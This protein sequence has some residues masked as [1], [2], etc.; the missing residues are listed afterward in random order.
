MMK[1]RPIG[2]P[3]FSPSF[4]LAEGADEGAACEESSELD[5]ESSVKTGPV[6]DSV[7]LPSSSTTRLSVR[8]AVGSPLSHAVD[9]L[10]KT[11]PGKLVEFREARISAVE[12]ELRAVLS[13]GKTWTVVLA[14][15]AKRVGSQVTGG[16]ML[17]CAL[18]MDGVGE[19]IWTLILD[20]CF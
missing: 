3:T 9:M 14:A 1:T 13:A 8:L 11:E 16:W 4:L 18:K 12:G 20:V 15:S 6:K 2:K 5:V 7:A 19:R 17:V 10:R